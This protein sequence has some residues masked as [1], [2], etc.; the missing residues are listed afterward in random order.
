MIRI[1]EK[2]PYEYKIS[3][4]NEVIDL[5]AWRDCINTKIGDVFT[6]GLSGGEKNKRASV[7]CEL[8]TDPDILLLDEPTSGLDAAASVSDK[9][10]E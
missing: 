6:G 10:D 3:R 7:A 8:L 9:N 2:V 4:L 1:A 5:L